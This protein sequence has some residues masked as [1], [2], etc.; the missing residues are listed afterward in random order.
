MEALR[1]SSPTVSQLLALVRA[2]LWQTPADAQPFT[3]DAADWEAI[4]TLALRQTVVL[5][6][7]E[8][9]MTLPASL[10]PSKAWLH[11]ARSYTLRNLRTY[12]LLNTSVAEA[13]D[14]LRSAGFHPVLLKGQAYAHYYPRPELRQCGDIDFYVGEDDYRPASEATQRFGWESREPFI[15]TNKHYG[16]SLHGIRIELHRVAALLAFPL[17]NRR[18]QTWSRRQL[19][20]TLCQVS[21][22]GKDIATP[23]PLFDVV[24][25]F[26]HLYHHFIN[27]GI[28][29]R[30]LCDWAVL[31]HAHHDRIDQQELQ[32]LLRSFGLLRAWRTFAPIVVDY[33]GLP[34]TECPLYTTRSAKQADKILAVIL[35]EGNFGHYSPS[36]SRKRRPYF[37]R[38]L[39]SFA[40]HSRRTFSLF[41]LAPASFAAYYCRF[42]YGAARKVLRELTTRKRK[43]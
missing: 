4:G 11:N 9:A 16:C 21:I 15:P 23:S 18:F 36:V 33:L 3:A 24:F 2:S 41:P 28:G 1:P 20:G 14:L 12:A 10:Q 26:L 37:L 31:L 25:V 30:H 35:R 8:G 5:L 39:H 38:K 43:V 13:T 32:R 34:A 22:G 29:L 6:T 7:I 27:S 42:L 40:F 17:A 19:A